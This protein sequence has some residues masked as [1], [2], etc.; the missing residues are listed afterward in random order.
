MVR[1]RNAR[2]IQQIQ[3]GTGYIIFSKYNPNQAR[4]LIK[5]PKHYLL[6]SL[7]LQLLQKLWH[8]RTCKSF[9]ISLI[10]CHIAF[11]ILIGATKYMGTIRKRKLCVYQSVSR[12]ISQELIITGSIKY[13]NDICRFQKVNFTPFYSLQW[14]N[15]IALDCLSHW[16]KN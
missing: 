8:K 11:P 6:C 9:L 12:T 14:S 16:I 10:N 5:A 7:N 15:Y 1:L 13:W 3:I 4:S 2:H